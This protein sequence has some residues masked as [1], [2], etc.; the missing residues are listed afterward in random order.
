MAVCWRAE[1]PASTGRRRC[2]RRVRDVL[3]ARLPCLRASHLALQLGG[4]GVGVLKQ[5]TLKGDDWIDA[6]GAKA[7]HRQRWSDVAVEALITHADRPRSVLAAKRQRD[8]PRD[9]LDVLII[10]RHELRSRRRTGRGARDHWGSPLGGVL[11]STPDPWALPPSPWFVASSAP[12]DP[13]VNQPA[14]WDSALAVC[15][16]GGRPP[17]ERL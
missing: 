7:D 16:P 11:L 9:L 14:A 10:Q 5:P 8:P 17:P 3:R 4:R 6:N 13:T 1:C 2:L 12:G 15:Q